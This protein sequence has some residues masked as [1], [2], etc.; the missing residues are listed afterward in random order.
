MK[1][2]D[3]L[4]T[5]FSSQIA[6]NFAAI[7]GTTGLTVDHAIPVTQAASRDFN[8]DLPQSKHQPLGVIQG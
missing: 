2:P 3:V 6:A 1:D 8:P 4:R 7:A 5:D